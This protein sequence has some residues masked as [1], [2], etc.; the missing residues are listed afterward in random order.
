MSVANN[1]DEAQRTASVMA[2]SVSAFAIEARHRRPIHM[3]RQ[4][5]ETWP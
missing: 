1:P 2:G 3:Q 4:L 5:A